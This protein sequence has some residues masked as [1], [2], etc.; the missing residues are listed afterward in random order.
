MKMNIN[1]IKIPEYFSPP[2]DEKYRLKEH[3]YIKSGYLRPIVVDGNNLLKDGYISY[4]IM[5]RSGVKE[6]E[7]VSDEDS[8][9]ATYI[10][11]THLNSKKEY[12]WMVPRR[13][14][15]RFVSSVTVGDKVYCYSNKR[16]AP[17]I[18]KSIFS[19]PKNSKYAQ[20]AGW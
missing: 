5:K 7:C 8:E 20:V 16:V 3:A 4:L 19:A 11:G 9:I 6:V 1:D 18:I 17:V 12:I 13:L 10:K 14:I 15:R 2:N